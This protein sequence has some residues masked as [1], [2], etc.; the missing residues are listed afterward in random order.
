[1]TGSRKATWRLVFLSYPCPAC[2]AAPG[3]VCM[4]TGGRPYGE[5][6]AARTR[7]AGR[8]PKCGSVVSAEL[9]PGSLCDRCA[10]VRSL[11]IERATTWKRRH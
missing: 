4:T 11:E 7:H 2:G 1:M 6:H 5:C 9:D 8:C 3:H 10:L